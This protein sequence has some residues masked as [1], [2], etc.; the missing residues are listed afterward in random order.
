[1]RRGLGVW[2]R[3][4]VVFPR[5]RSVALNSGAQSVVGVLQRGS[6]GGPGLEVVSQEAGRVV[7][8]GAR[9]RALLALP[10]R[11]DHDGFVNL[12]HETKQLVNFS[13]KSLSEF[14]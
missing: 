3:G 5:V 10:G 13:F 11:G 7:A 2:S 9:A 6:V 1:M 12:T 4:R 8:R 14:R